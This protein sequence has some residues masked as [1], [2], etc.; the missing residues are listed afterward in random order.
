MWIPHIVYPDHE[1]VESWDGMGWAFL[2]PKEPR[3]KGKIVFLTDGD[4][5]S[6]A[7]SFMGYIEGFK[8]AEIVGSPTAGT[9]GDVNP[10]D[11]PGGYTF[12]WTGLKVTKFDGSQHH[13]IG[14]QPTVPLARTLKAVL[15]GRDEFVEK[16]VELINRS[17]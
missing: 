11:L 15:E 13:L 12:T 9:N 10:I 1:R 17:R 5:V 14:I 6:Y 16:A 3:L 7:E 8:L 2:Q 4:V